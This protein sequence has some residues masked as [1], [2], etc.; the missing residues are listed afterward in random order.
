MKGWG[1][2]SDKVRL[3]ELYDWLDHDG[4]GQVTWNDF[5]ISAG[6]ELAPME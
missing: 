6:S 4:D 1:F 3:R 5:R 2:A